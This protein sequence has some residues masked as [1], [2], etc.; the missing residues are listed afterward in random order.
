MDDKSRIKLGLFVE[1][2]EK[3]AKYVSEMSYY[4][5][6]I[7]VFRSIEEDV[8]QIH[9]AI[10]GFILV[11]DHVDEALPHIKCACL[12]LVDGNLV[13]DCSLEKNSL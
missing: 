7:G 8:W 1:K 13:L 5:G 9:Q 12:L 10:E 4:G 11:F 2:A 6:L 3:L